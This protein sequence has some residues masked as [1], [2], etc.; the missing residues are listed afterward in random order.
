MKKTNHIVHLPRAYPSQIAP[1]SSIF[2]KEQI[3]AISQQNNTI[4]LGVLAIIQ[5]PILKQLLLRNSQLLFSTNKNIE[6]NITTW[7]KFLFTI[8][9]P[10]KIKRQYIN[11]S[12]LVLFKKY[13]S[14]HGKPDLI[15][16]QT[17]EMGAVA[18]KILK[19]YGIPYIVTEHSSNL[20]NDKTR[21]SHDFLKKIYLKSSF[22]IAV[23]PFFSDY[24]TKK[25]GIP[26]NTIPNTVDTD[27]F[28]L[29]PKKKSSKIN[30]LHVAN[31]VEI[32]QQ[33]LLIQ[34]YSEALKHNQ[35]LN[36]TIVGDGPQLKSLKALVIE[37]DIDSYVNF[38]GRLS[39]EDVKIQMHLADIF[40]LT[41]KKETFGVVLIEALAVRLPCITTKSGG[42]EGIITDEELGQICDHNAEDIAKAILS[43]SSKEY[44]S[45]KIREHVVSTYSSK[46]VAG[47]INKVYEKILIN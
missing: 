39:N 16:L 42:P 47:Q 1:L 14:T 9:L 13:I 29:K 7:V 10:R 41:S 21:L 23:S 38:M 18:L 46:I 12:L 32:K 25:F 37:L 22:N 15:H 31:C 27:K 19:K 36:L 28:T 2:F 26:F 24:L 17:Y 43:V 6:R 5:R 30:L 33:K 44:D 40:I 20:Y 4:K 3:E 8:P 34:G 35:L 45:K 11:F